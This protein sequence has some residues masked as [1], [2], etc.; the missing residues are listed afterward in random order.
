MTWIVTAPDKDNKYKL[1][2]KKGIDK[3]GLLPKGSYLTI[4]DT[5]N[6]DKS[7]C[8]LRVEQSSHEHPYT[9]STM[10]VDMNLGSIKADLKWQNHLL[11]VL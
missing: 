5:E 1:V 9:P 10:S 3:Q 4:I 11:L 7:L 2:S 6:A 8:V